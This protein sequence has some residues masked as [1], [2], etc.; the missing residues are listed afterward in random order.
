MA[1]KILEI[2]PECGKRLKSWLEKCGYTERE[3][4][5]AI[6]YSPQ[7][8]S[9][10]ITGK[11]RLTAE[12]AEALE[13]WS[14]EKQEG[15]HK[16]DK[17]LVLYEDRAV[18]AEWL[19]CKDEYMT[20]DTLDIEE[21][22]Q[23][24]KALEEDDVLSGLLREEIEAMGYSLVFHFYND[25]PG[26]DCPPWAEDGYYELVNTSS[27]ETEATFPDIELKQLVWEYRDFSK[28]L[29]ENFI[30]RFQ[31]ETRKR[32]KA[33]YAKMERK[34]QSNKEGE[35]GKSTGKKK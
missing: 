10:V 20:R 32:V 13:R 2:N 25:Y 35:H 3:V 7:H 27:G 28:V 22:Q 23:M 1:R 33:E 11:K 34:L 24:E 5:E 14:K 19:L 15:A 30:K 17:G 31:P 26:Y 18:R 9:G 8:L 21:E 16:N 4:A 6:H 29:A 12:L